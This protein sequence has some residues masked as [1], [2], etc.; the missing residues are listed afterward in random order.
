MQSGETARER[1]DFC[2]CF[3]TGAAV[4]L[5]DDG[6]VAHSTYRNTLRA[7]YMLARTNCTRAAASISEYECDGCARPTCSEPFCLR[8][9]VTA[10][11]GAR[12]HVGD[13]G[14]GLGSFGK[15]GPGR[16]MP[17]SNRRW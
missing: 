8:L 6:I 16:L 10:C 5:H 13:K 11:Q 15:G 1:A 17:P 12:G 3:K 2:G 4:F 7:A 9:S 14:P